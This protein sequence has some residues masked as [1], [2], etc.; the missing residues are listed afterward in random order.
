MT[1]FALMLLVLC[2]SLFGCAH[3]NAN[4]VCTTPQF[5]VMD[6][7][8]QDQGQEHRLQLRAGEP[9]TVGK[10]FALYLNVPKPVFV[11]VW[12]ID[13]VA[14]RRL[15]RTDSMLAPSQNLRLPQDL[16]HWLS[17]GSQDSG[18]LCV[19]ASS[20]PITDGPVLCKKNLPPV[21]YGC[22]VPGSRPGSSRRGDAAADD[23][24]D[25]KK[26]DGESKPVTTS[27][28]P[29]D[30]KGPDKRPIGPLGLGVWLLLQEGITRI[31]FAAI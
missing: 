8:E 11:E 26:A 20:I 28:P 17:W 13:G 15:V 27:D 19:L 12:A 22:A 6:I 14:T 18:Q 5:A 2:M 3:R 4:T 30:E 25:G 24:S 29:P 31:T 7:V 1:R 10:P 23:K 21:E 9:L 16:A